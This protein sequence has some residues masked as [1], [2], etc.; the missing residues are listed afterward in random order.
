MRIKLD[1][2]NPITMSTNWPMHIVNKQ[3]SGTVYFVQH[4]S[5]KTGSEIKDTETKKKHIML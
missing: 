4:E 2:S 3:E 1:K 5:E